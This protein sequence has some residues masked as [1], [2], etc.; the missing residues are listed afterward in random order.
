MS[1][2]HEREGTVSLVKAALEKG[3]PLFK[4]DVPGHEF[5]GN[6]YT[7]GG[8]GGAA[9]SGKDYKDGGQA[10]KLAEQHSKNADKLSVKAKN[11][12]TRA[13]DRSAAQAAKEASNYH[14]EARFNATSKAVNEY[15][16]KQADK[17]QR[18]SDE[19]YNRARG[20]K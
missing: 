15:H 12:G 3:T 20:D 1:N 18:M 17:Y 2:L 5:R 6:Q 19:H 9:G 8:E 7:G 4:G 13:M 11:G 16:D 10:A 14:A